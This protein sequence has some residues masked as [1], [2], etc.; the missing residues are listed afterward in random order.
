MRYLPLLLA[1]TLP[2]LAEEAVAP[3]HIEYTVIEDKATL[4]ILNPVLEGRKV[5]KIQLDNGL[6][7]LL[8]SDPGADQSAAGVAVDSGSWEDPKEY[9]GMAHFLEH[10]LF[11]GNGAYPNE[12]EY[13][14]FIADHGGGVNAFTASDRTVY[15]FSVNNDAFDESL[16]RFSH[17]FIDP[18][19]SPNCI[20]RELHAVDQ[21]H[22]K[23][24]E[25]D[26]W[27]QYM[28]LKETG[29]PAHPNCGFSTGNAQTLSG[30][31]Q[32][33][34]RNWYESHYSASQMHLVMIS[35]LAI[36]EMRALASQDF[37]KVPN[38]SVSRKE[39]SA[40]ITCAKQRGHMIFIKPVKDIKQL[41][42]TW[43]VPAPFAE[44]IER[45][46]PDLVAYALGQEG[47]HSLTQILKNEK[48]AESVRVS[49]DRFSKQ[50]LFFAVDINLTD[51]GITQIDTAITRVY[52]AIARIKK[53][54][55][56]THLFTDLQTMAKL[57]YQYQSRDD[58][59]HTIMTMASELPYEDLA[60]YPEKTR[61]PSK[62]D[63]AFIQ[64]FVDSLKAETCVYFVLADPSKTGV[65]TDTKEKWM[66]AEYAVKGVQHSR[67]TAWNNVAPNPSILL[68]SK[69]PY[70]PSDLAL[71]DSAT[72]ANAESPLLLSSDNGSTVYYAA[73]TRYKVPEIAFSFSF[74]SP[75]IDTTSKSQVLT[76]LYLRALSEKVS[77]ELS[78]A[79]AAGLYTRF[80]SDD[81]EIKMTLC[82]YNDKAPLLLNE[83]FSSFKTVAPTKEEF[84]I[85]R[86]SLASDYDNA[87]KELP[88]RQAMEHLDGILFNTPSNQDKLTT[89]KAITYEDFT[90][91]AK[92]LFESAYTEGLLY[93]NITQ[94]DAQT[95]WSNL[96]G[97][98]DSQPY[99]AQ[100]QHK[101]KVL[102]LSDKFGPYKLSQTTDRQGSGVLLLLQEGP[103]SFQN[104]A[105]Q[106][107][108][109][110]ALTDAFF[111]TLR[112]KQQTAY[113][114]KA[115]NTEEQRQLLQF[116]AVQSS[117]HSPTDLLARFELF[118]ESFDKNL[119]VQIPEGRFESIRST[120]I[121]LVKMPPENMP[122]MAAQLDELA[123]EYHDFK[124]LEKRIESLKNLTYGQ[125]CEVSHQL[126]SRNNPRRLAVLM[127]GAM[128]PEND[129]HY[130]L[131]TKED[132]H[133]LGTFS[134][135]K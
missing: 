36:D 125:F 99:L 7:V 62:F 75:L 18:L 79:S 102:I 127:E 78:R 129:F 4:P 16:D 98:L 60:T 95:L 101:K 61:I 67:L 2:L 85:Y 82:G 96:K 94:Q 6:Q 42:L 33:A 1:A 17:F 84:E 22:S 10:M 41:S 108:L 69:N 90:H 113:I 133:S 92:S 120:L 117:T 11:M 77:A 68:P 112:T 81:Y 97:Q 126:L 100:D 14:Q 15:M 80:L 131:V 76:D 47:E 134:S 64:S 35:P 106:Q 103:F 28:I 43:E 91:F 56:P 86:T 38:L 53:E 31:P 115:W 37:S 116:F 32:S 105:I 59:F 83:V 66:N 124:F 123:F 110:F 46:A 71:I 104:R 12:F 54:G 8:I 128:N 118:L 52:Q 135:V 21:E 51:H 48:I 121:T 88:V 27:R 73:D 57:N 107:V 24:I 50:S 29:N 34:L 9:P 3:S 93:G 26:G 70:M 119:S 132:V 87:S 63:P 89:I 130:E 30:I 114:A 65:A 40:D 44:D 19:F 109:G 49:C 55:F 111:D 23:N 5:E 20:N 45:R 13:M 122:G 58:A 72:E 25:N 74:K 39:I